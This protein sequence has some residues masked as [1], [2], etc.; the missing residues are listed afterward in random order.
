MLLEGKHTDTWTEWNFLTKHGNSNVGT[1][2]LT[3]VVMKISSVWDITPCNPLKF[4]QHF[5][6]VC[7]FRVQG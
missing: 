3:I 7:R 5:G 6:G 2:V 4:N 1:D